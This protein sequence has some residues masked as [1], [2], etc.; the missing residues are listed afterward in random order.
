M[1]YIRISIKRGRIWSMRNDKIKKYV[2]EIL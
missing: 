1:M 2:N